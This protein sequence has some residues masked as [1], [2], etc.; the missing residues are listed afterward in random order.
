M[1]TLHIRLLGDFAL[2][3]GDDPI[4]S[5]S[6]PRLQSFIGY[7]ALNRRSPQPR[8]RIA[9]LFWPDSEET[10]ARTNLRKLIYDLRQTWPVVDK[11]IQ[12]D[13]S[14]IRLQER[15][16]FTLDIE[17][18]EKLAKQ[19]D[20]TASL[21]AA[22]DRYGGML[23]PNCYDDWVI[24]ERQR[25]HQLYLDTLENLVE[26]LEKQ[27]DYQGAIRYSRSLLKQAPL[28]EDNYRRLMRLYA[29]NGDRAGVLRTYHAC[30][31]AL[32]REL[33]V[34]PSQITQKLYN[35][36]LHLEKPLSQLPP[37]P[38]RLVGRESEW[39][40]LQEIWRKA[41]DGQ[42]NWVVLAGEQG[43]GKT[44]L[45]EELVQWAGRQGVETI[46]IKCSPVDKDLAY[47][48]VTSILR[49]RPLPPLNKIWLTDISRLLP[50]IL[51][52]H[53]Q[54]SSP[55]SL[56]EDWQRHRFFDA[57]SR[58]L[59]AKQ[60]LL[61]FIDDLQW[62]DPDS[63]QWLNYLVQLE[64]EAR[65]LLIS[66]LGFED[67]E[68]GH[69]LVS[70]LPRLRK[71]SRI[72]EIS[73]EPLSQAETYQ[74][75]GNLSDDN[76]PLLDD[77]QLYD[78]TGGNPLHTVEMMRAGFS[79]DG[80]DK[81]PG[82]LPDVQN[83]MEKRISDLSPE[84]Q[85]LTHLA[86]TLGRPF[87]A[88]MLS[89]VDETSEEE[90]V[91]GL[92]E[93]WQQQVLREHNTDS[94]DFS[95]PKFGEVAYAG[96]SDAQRRDL[97]RQVAE[98]LAASVQGQDSLLDAEIAAHYEK[99]GLVD[100]A[101]AYYIKSGH[102]AQN[103]YAFQA[104]INYYQ[105]ALSLSPQGENIQVLLKLGD[106]RRSLG[107]WAVAEAL[108]RQ[109]YRLAESHEDPQAL[110]QCQAAIGQILYLK[111]QHDQALEW[112]QQARDNFVDRGDQPSLSRV[113]RAM[114]KV[115]LRTLD[116]QNAIRCHQKELELAEQ[117]NDHQMIADANGNLAMIVWQ[118]GDIERA[119][120]LF[121]TQ[122]E[123]A[124]QTGD[125][126]G[127]LSARVHIG[128]VR[129][130][131]GDFKS[132]LNLFNQALQDAQKTGDRLAAAQIMGNVGKL[133]RVQGDLHRALDYF[134]DQY[135]ITAN[136]GR[137]S[138]AARAI[139][140]IGRVFWD[141]GEHQKA[142]LCFTY[143]LKSGLETG[144]RLAISRALGDIAVIFIHQ[145]DYPR[146]AQLLDRVIRLMREAGLE[147]Q[148]CKHLYY[149][150]VLSQI[151]GKCQR[152]QQMNC[153][154]LELAE[155]AERRE[156]HFKADLLSFRLQVCLQSIQTAKAIQELESRLKQWSRDEEQ[157]A[158]HYQ[159]WRLDSQQDEH[160]QEASRLYRE[161]SRRSQKFEYRQ[162]YHALTGER[163]P[164]GADQPELPEFIR[165]Q[166]ID[167]EKL[168]T[169]AEHV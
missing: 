133:Y 169:Q 102:A 74:L 25:L 155:Q 45:A 146:A 131:Q 14:E 70:L 165:D 64:P 142:L 43:V 47:S 80:P 127:Y 24:E 30:A 95:H 166:E 124:R 34:E 136:I 66:T 39:A 38:S 28:Q 82:D 148:L 125:T 27:R 13:G 109:A 126:H 17:E 101:V 44:R 113:F 61:V 140:N 85:K 2:S 100:R 79:L 153:Q 29:L 33:E 150:A 56:K 107:N 4:T 84:A 105:R 75:A 37:P 7:V 1:E 9:Y 53:P 36:L 97:H 118:L 159:I 147:Y 76:S 134:I 32:Q 160:R 63:L 115:Y 163:L 71:R 119:L 22:I 57:L 117:A 69:P 49:A 35:Q 87:T 93:L 23:L 145:K 110:A 141:F 168:L 60:P 55:G 58:A 26:D 3:A 106:V 15:A 162:R 52:D 5:L 112:L 8:R 164:P 68:D 59:L 40:Q 20:T 72:T 144:N 12:L 65:L 48:L 143:S 151:R 156:I 99:A 167:L 31:T 121:Q 51:V 42:L 135:E 114:G 81:P 50:E 91:K 103:L 18:F 90:L 122:L 88:Q 21:K 111:G 46:S 132:A 98:L 54:I 78:R 96:L 158:I 149:R 92:D 138:E 6:A 94:Y 108:Y 104:A 157:A 137:R 161:L 154:A 130:A 67:L 123:V 139:K 19:A 116:L 129:L 11:Y 16:A 89:Q 10:Q 152:A 41:M 73:L 120:P 83:A 128:R 77:R 62:S 86:A